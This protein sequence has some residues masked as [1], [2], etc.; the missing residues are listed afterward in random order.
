MTKTGIEPGSSCC[1]ECLR[2]EG[3]KICAPTL[4]YLC[5]NFSF[6]WYRRD[7]RDMLTSGEVKPVVLGA[8][9]PRENAANLKTTGWEFP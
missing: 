7:T 9:V 8:S 2:Y 6:D 4:T 5:L 1:D 3:Q